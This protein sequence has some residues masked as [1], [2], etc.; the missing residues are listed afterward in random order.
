MTALVSLLDEDK[1][2]HDVNEH[3]QHQLF[4]HENIMKV[5]SYLLPCGR[6]VCRCG[7]SR[8]RNKS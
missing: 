8:L 6:I 7:E 4:D 5:S 3:Y 2:L 1:T